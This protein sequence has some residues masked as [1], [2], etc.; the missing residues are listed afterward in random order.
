MY[1][2]TNL[3]LCKL[4][5]Y[6]QHFTVTSCVELSPVINKCVLVQVCNTVQAARNSGRLSTDGISN[7][8]KRIMEVCDRN[9]TTLCPI[10]NT[11]KLFW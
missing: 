6:Q 9:D 4:F 5:S 8:T 1:I 3:G 11:P 2:D 7:L 10:K